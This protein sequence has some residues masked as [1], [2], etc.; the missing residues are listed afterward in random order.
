MVNSANLTNNEADC[1]RETNSFQVRVD[2]PV[3]FPK[4]ETAPMLTRRRLR[5]AAY[6]FY[7]RLTPLVLTP[8]RHQA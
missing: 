4:R 5:A 8:L 3:L 2:A 1:T 6:C 7:V